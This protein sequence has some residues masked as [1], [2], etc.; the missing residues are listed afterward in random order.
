MM[1][2]TQSTAQAF[3]NRRLFS[4]VIQVRFHGA[5]IASRYYFTLTY[6]PDLMW[7]RAAPLRQDGVF[8][9]TEFKG[10]RRYKGRKKWVL[11]PEQE[12]EEIDVSAFAC[13]LVQSEACM[14]TPDADDEVRGNVLGLLLPLPTLTAQERAGVQ[15]CLRLPLQ[16]LCDCRS[17]PLQNQ[18][19]VT[20]NNRWCPS[21]Q[22]LT[23]PPNCAASRHLR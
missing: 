18:T 8:D 12:S 1:T 21:S 3:L 13:R 22:W 2:C 15:L 17:G 10:A 5:E 11:V 20:D 9:G 7:V 19:N 23:T 4:V 6:L 16:L 14:N